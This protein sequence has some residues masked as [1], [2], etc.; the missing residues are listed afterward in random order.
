[1]TTQISNSWR[2]RL[3]ERLHGI[4]IQLVTLTERMAALDVQNIRN[5][6]K[7]LEK[8][9]A[10]LQVKAGVWGMLAGLIPAVAVFI[11]WLVKSG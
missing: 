11:W 8:Q 9:V 10:S 7:A 2:E 1:V 6:I 4:E 3:T 5:E